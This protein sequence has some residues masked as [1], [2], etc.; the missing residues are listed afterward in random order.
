MVYNFHNK[1][2]VVAD[3]SV[4]STQI[5]KFEN[6]RMNQLMRRGGALLL[7]HYP[8][9]Q[10]QTMNTANRNFLLSPLL[11]GMSSADDRGITPPTDSYFLQQTQ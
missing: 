7:P 5:E 9:I 8:N 3:D 10:T 6:K 2:N 11:R 4:R 1:L